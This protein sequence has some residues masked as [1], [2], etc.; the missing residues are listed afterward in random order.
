MQTLVYIY[1]TITFI[2]FFFIYGQLLLDNKIKSNNNVNKTKE[3]KEFE[4]MGKIYQTTFKLLFTYAG[5]LVLYSY[6]SATKESVIVYLLFILPIF[7]D[8]FDRLEVN[9]KSLWYYFYL[10]CIIIN[11][12]SFLVGC[13]ALTKYTLIIQVQG[14]ILFTIC[15]NIGILLLDFGI[16]AY[17]FRKK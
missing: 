17:Q 12:L 7:M 10:L 5:A 3:E 9:K 4:K 14:F 13:I 15:F 8:M 2:I 1:L 6:L 16:A 11:G